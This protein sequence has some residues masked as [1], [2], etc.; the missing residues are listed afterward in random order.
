MPALMLGALCAC[1]AD[2]QCVLHAV[3][4]ASAVAL[5]LDVDILTPAASEP[6]RVAVLKQCFR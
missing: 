5:E 4:F 6:V 1:Y 3:H 2:L